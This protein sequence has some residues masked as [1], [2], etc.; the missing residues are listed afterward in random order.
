DSLAENIIAAVVDGAQTLVSGEEVTL[1]TAADAML[2]GIR[3]PNGTALSGK[4]ILSGE[5]LLVTINATRIGSRVVPVA[6]EVMDMDGMTGIRVQGSITRDASKESADQAMGA[7]GITSMDAGVAGQV[8]AAGFQAAKT[9]L[10]RKIR[11][12]RVGLP[13]GYKVWLKNTKSNR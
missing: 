3:V 9:L 5:R 6:L 2:G 7:L 8:T 13:A 11:L 10:S 1:R 12:V 4:A